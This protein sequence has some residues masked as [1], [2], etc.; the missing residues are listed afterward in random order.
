MTS[1]DEEITAIKAFVIGRIGRGDRLGDGV[2]NGKGLCGGVGI[3]E[4]SAV[5]AGNDK[6][7]GGGLHCGVV[8][9]REG[10]N[11]IFSMLA[12]VSVKTAFVS[13][14]NPKTVERS[15]ISK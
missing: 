3:G 5:V 15:G 2:N 13:A 14:T 11:K 10:E 7:V 8:T 1:G 6:R 12:S 9:P 4:A